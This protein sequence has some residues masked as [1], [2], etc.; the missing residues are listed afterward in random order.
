MILTS[1]FKRYMFF[2]S[3]SYAFLFFSLGILYDLGITRK[4]EVIIVQREDLVSEHIGGTAKQ[5]K[6]V[7]QRAADGMLFIDEAYRLFYEGALSKD[8]GKEAI[9]TIMRYM[10]D[11]SNPR[12]IFV[13]AGYKIQMEEFLKSNSGLKRRIQYTFDFKDYTPYEL[14]VMLRR[15]LVRAGYVIPQDELDFEAY[16][17]GLSPEIRSSH[18]A[19]LV[20]KLKVA[21]QFA[22]E[23]RLPFDCPR[24]SLRSLKL[25]D[26]LKGLQL[27]TEGHSGLVVSEK[28]DVGTSTDDLIEMRDVELQTNRVSRPPIRL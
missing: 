14:G 1:E 19:G 7:I 23:E 9:D 21:I 10:N 11:E 2:T 22:Q 28:R 3:S 24:S 17:D 6:K 5:T 26:F 18:N 4:E 25:Q 16:I 15:E 13:F 12:V 27:F 20:E 8:Y